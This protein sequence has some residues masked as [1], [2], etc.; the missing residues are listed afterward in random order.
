MYEKLDQIGALL[1][2]AD[3]AGNIPE[4][5][6]L[7]KLYIEEET[8]VNKALQLGR[9]MFYAE[10]E[11]ALSR[12]I[13]MLQGQLGSAVEG[14]GQ[15]F[16]LEGLE[17]YGAKVALD[18]EYQ[19]QLQ[20]QFATRLK[21]VEGVGSGL[22][23]AKDAFV[24]SLPFM[25]PG[26]AGM[27]S[28]FLAAGPPGAI[29][30]GIAALTP[31]F[32]GGNIQRTQDYKE[33]QGESRKLTDEEIE[34]AAKASVFQASL[35]FIAQ[36]VLFGRLVPD[37]AIR[38]TGN[39][40]TRTL[41]GAG[42]GAGTEIPTEVGQ[43]LIE[44][45]QAGMPIADDAAINEY[46]EAAVAAGIVGGGIKGAGSAIQG[47][48]AEPTKEIDL[49]LKSGQ[50][51]LDVDQPDRPYQPDQPDQPDPEELVQV[52]RDE[53]VTLGMADNNTLTD[54]LADKF[55]P[56]STLRN[57]LE[58]Y[59]RS[60]PLEE[61]GKISKFLRDKETSE[62]QLELDLAEPV[63]KKEETR[64]APE[65][66]KKEEETQLSLDLESPLQ[67]ERSELT[68][69]VE[70]TEPEELIQVTQEDL[71]EIG[72]VKTA[73]IRKRLVEP[74]PLSEVE[75]ELEGY[76]AV[77][78]T[79]DSPQAQKVKG[80]IVKFLQS[81]KT[82]KD[83]LELDLPLRVD[84]KKPLTYLKNKLRLTSSLTSEADTPLLLLKPKKNLKV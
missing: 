52:T 60:R 68:E 44:R 54:D 70:V 6:E 83:Q 59:A 41:K 57:E 76:A 73:P 80:S 66:V 33:A 30:G 50:V 19:L 14:F 23:Y 72:V 18:N 7:A 34:T 38:K 74:K 12:G 21:D 4:A 37:S 8:K 75:R 1:E 71:D 40:F 11:G 39:I 84:K 15:Y 17:E 49:D 79:K 82:S 5:K 51:L 31:Q 56:L 81:K 20:E 24:E 65:P 77:K 9:D 78:F 62:T 47:P 55:V 63:K 27:G 28:G 67:P 64:D 22:S 69:P 16:G 29:V 26:L 13:D 42:V 43:N 61:R 45:L 2:S 48:Q 10:D 32:F 36:K 35:D 46:I 53:L 58:K 25:A 3:A